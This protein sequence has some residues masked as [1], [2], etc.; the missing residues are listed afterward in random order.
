M[1]PGEVRCCGSSAGWPDLP[2]GLHGTACGAAGLAAVLRVLN[3]LLTVEDTT[4]VAI[5]GVAVDGARDLLAKQVCD[6]RRL[7]MGLGEGRRPG[8]RHQ[9]K[10]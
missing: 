10:R 9:E 1:P 2:R 4:R 7:R 8:R 5:L 6:G 3:P